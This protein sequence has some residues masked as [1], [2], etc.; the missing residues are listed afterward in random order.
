MIC[1]RD[2]ISIRRLARAWR[3]AWLGADVESL[4]ALFTDT[5]VVILQG[6]VTVALGRG[7]V[8]ALL[9]TALE[10]RADNSAPGAPD[11]DIEGALDVQGDWA[12]YRSRFAL[13]A[14]I[15]VNG[16][17]VRSA[18]STLFILRREAPETWK[19]ASLLA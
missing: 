10:Q 12:S 15:R 13:N 17:L 1:E 16:G 18:G 8:R 19:I 14:A 5:P 3:E 2:V 7:E 9:R 11:A 6:G 4:G